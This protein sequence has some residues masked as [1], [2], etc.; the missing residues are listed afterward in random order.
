MAIR[1]KRRKK[2]TWFPTHGTSIPQIAGQQQ[3]IASPY[4]F[5]LSFDGQVT[6][7]HH[8]FPLVIP[9]YPVEE[10]GADTLSDILGSEYLVERIVGKFFATSYAN[11][12]DTPTAALVSL[13]IFVA[14]ADGNDPTQPAGGGTAV[15]S[16]E[17]SSRNF[18][19]QDFQTIRE[20]WMFRRS[21]VLSHYWP[22][23]NTSTGAPLQV[24]S[25]AQA[26]NRWPATTA[27]YGSVA[28]GP[29]IDVKSVRRVR[30]DERLWGVISAQP[31]PFPGG[32]PSIVAGSQYRVEG[33]FDYRVLGALRK[34]KNRSNF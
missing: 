25:Q 22:I 27:G 21:W 10:T 34:A 8:I 18:N 14:R 7:G 28:D 5:Q 6:V 12:S 11:I 19:P 24:P 32:S 26:W 31:V 20:P 9:D 17:E 1:R 33:V 30:Q 3:Y 29:H 2:Y 13:G 4:G 15:A 16:V 23:V